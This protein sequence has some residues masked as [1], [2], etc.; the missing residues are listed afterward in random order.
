MP[1]QERQCVPRLAGA[2]VGAWRGIQ[3]PHREFP[4]RNPKYKR[5]RIPK[6]TNSLHLVCEEICDVTWTSEKHPK[7]LRMG[8]I[9]VLTDRGLPKGKAV[10]RVLVPLLRSRGCADIESLRT[11]QRL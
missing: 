10:E 11:I 6:L 1:L 3:D 9:F 2:R 8:I 7:D 4:L 5:Q